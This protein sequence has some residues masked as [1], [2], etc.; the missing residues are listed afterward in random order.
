MS[1]QQNDNFY[2]Y[3]KQL[4]EGYV[5][6]GLLTDKEMRKLLDNPDVPSAEEEDNGEMPEP[7]DQD[8]NCCVP[9]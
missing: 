7:Y 5:A 8:G 1:L 3:H 9:A 6:Q 4:L 2:E